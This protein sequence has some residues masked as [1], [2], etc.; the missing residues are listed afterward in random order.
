MKINQ[1]FLGDEHVKSVQQAL[2]LFIKQQPIDHFPQTVIQTVHF[3]TNLYPNIESITSKFENSNPDQG[4]DLT[5]Y[6][7]NNTITVNL[8]LIRKGGRI[9]P[10]NPGAKSFFSKYFLSEQLQDMFNKAFEKNYLEYLKELV[11][12]KEKLL[13]VQDK[14]ELKKLASSYFPKFNEEINPYRDKFLYR[15]REKSFALLKDFYNEKS[16]GFFNAYNVFFMTED[17]N[18]ITSYGKKE[19]DVT[20]EEFNLGTPR[21]GDIQIYKNGKSTVGI[22]YGNVGLTLRFKFE[23]SPTSSIKLA[24]SFEEFPDESEI[25]AVNGRT[26][27]K[28]ADLLSCHKFIQTSNSSN[29]IGKCHEAFTYYYFLKE[30]QDISQVEPD[31][32]VQLMTQYYNLVNPV[33]LEKLYKSTITI[34]PIIREKLNEKYSTFII[35]S[36]ELVPDSYII[37]RLNTGDIQLILKVNDEYVVENI[38]LKALA[39]KSSKITTKNPGIGTILGPTYFNVGSIDS[40]VREVKSKFQ[41]GV[42]SHKESLEI[43]SGELG[44]Q[45]E[46]A[47]QDQLKQGIENLLGKP[48]MAVTFYDESISYCLEHAQINSIIKVYLKKPSSIQNTLAWNNDLE[49]INL[50]VKF[51]RGHEH[52]WSTIKLTSEYQLK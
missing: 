39:K 33:V 22:K 43:L 44:L 42:L 40:I 48:M 51:S 3:I 9:Q 1:R 41:I 6:L 47:T 23:S 2:L 10:K 11:S 31:E 14:R 13:Y 7:K 45:L 35:E 17:V 8:F 32:C 21:F 26:I 20:V 34:V 25:E 50:R 19:K 38:S 52:G 16:E 46:K 24:V 30:F 28:V 27:Q 49:T 12:L 5:L 18:I 36:I 15:L 37:D 29:A 4:K